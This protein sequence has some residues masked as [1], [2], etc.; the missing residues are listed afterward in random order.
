[1]GRYYYHKKQTS[2]QCCGLSICNLKKYGLLTGYDSGTI[3]WTNSRTGQVTIVTLTADLQDA[4]YVRLEYTLT[5]NAGNKTDYES[6]VGLVKTTCNYGGERFWFGCPWCDRRVAT[7][8]LPPGEA[9]FRCRHC[10][11]L[12]YWS[13]NRSRIAQWGYIGRERENL[14]SQI[15]RWTWRGRPTRKVRKLL[16]L[17]QKEGILAGAEI[18]RLK[19]WKSWYLKK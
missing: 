13:R 3:S 10:Y 8:Y 11:N 5:D 7:L 15:K 17:Q 18:A 16:N 9:E 6:E 2:E 19:R 12:T 4:T 14:Q 1:M